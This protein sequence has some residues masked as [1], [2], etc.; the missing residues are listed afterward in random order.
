MHLVLKSADNGE[1]WRYAGILIEKM[2][3]PKDSECCA[4]HG[5]CFEMDK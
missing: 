5:T 1:N 3:M 2:A 4:K